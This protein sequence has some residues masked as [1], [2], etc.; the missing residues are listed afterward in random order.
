[1]MRADCVVYERHAF[2]ENYRD[3]SIKRAVCVIGIQ[4]ALAR[5]FSLILLCLQT[6]KKSY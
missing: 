5:A 6:N 2:M 1:M 4:R 3:L